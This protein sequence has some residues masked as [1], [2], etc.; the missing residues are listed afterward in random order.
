MILLEPLLKNSRTILVDNLTNI[1]KPD[2]T[3]LITNDQSIPSYQAEEFIN[4]YGPTAQNAYAPEQVIRLEIY[5][6]QVGITRRFIGM[7][8]DLTG[9]SIIVKNLITRS[10]QSMLKRAHEIITLLDGNWG[11]PSLI[12]Q[13]DDYEDLE[14]CILSPI[15]FLGSSA[16]EEVYEDHFHMSDTRETDRPE[17]LFLELSFGGM[18]VYTNK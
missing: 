17:G 14:F 10:K 2:N 15:G 3:I 9:E 16:I 4:V 1:S 18:Q 6:F 12:R 13:D 11:I 7:A 5:G 8:P